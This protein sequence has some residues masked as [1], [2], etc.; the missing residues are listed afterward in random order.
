MKIRIYI[1]RFLTL[2]CKYFG[3]WQRLKKIESDIVG[4]KGMEFPI[5]DSQ[6][7]IENKKQEYYIRTLEEIN[8][9]KDWLFNKKHSTDD[10]IAILFNIVKTS[11]FD[12]N[13]DA[14]QLNYDYEKILS[15]KSF[16]S[17]LSEEQKEQIIKQICYKL[18]NDPVYTVI[19]NFIFKLVHY[20]STEQQDYF[21]HYLF[22]LSISIDKYFKVKIIKH[23]LGFTSLQDLYCHLSIKEM[24]CLIILYA[25][26]SFMLFSLFPFCEMG[27]LK[28]LMLHSSFKKFLI[29][30]GEQKI[31]K[32]NYNDTIANE[33]GKIKFAED[34][35]NMVSNQYPL[36]LRIPIEMFDEIIDTFNSTKRLAN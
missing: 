3:I 14:I 31:G 26:K 6:I 9:D 17:R 32:D 7:W 36:R 30:L 8:N 21:I 19:P 18:S 24:Y 25:E 5:S 23:I 22:N 13:S 15:S 34:L 33:E 35:L 10:D 16:L 4:N 27:I 28:D 11:Y 1:N 29:K 12:A 2:Y 20:L